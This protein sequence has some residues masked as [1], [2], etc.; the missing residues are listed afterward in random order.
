MAV[1]KTTQEFVPIKEVRDGIA[2]LKDGSMRAILMASATNFALKSADEQKS[3]IYQFQN[4]LNSIN[5]DIQIFVQSR[6]LDIRPYVSLLEQRERE[7]TNELM[8]VQTREYINFIKN[9][10]EQSNIMTKR[11][12]ITIPYTPP[13]LEGT[14]KKSI[15]GLF[16][17]TNENLYR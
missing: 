2:I 17:K 9:F 3:I 13:V 10:T 15:L 16:K 1:I 6:R 8:R 5:F 7:Q 4:F 12:F 14:D 11:F